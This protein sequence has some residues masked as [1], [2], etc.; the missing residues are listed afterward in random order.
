MVFPRFLTLYRPNNTTSRDPY[1]PSSPDPP[2]GHDPRARGPGSRGAWLVAFL[3][4]GQ[5]GR[6][7]TTSRVPPM[8]RDP[9]PFLIDGVPPTGLQVL[10]SGVGKVVARSGRPPEALIKEGSL[11]DAPQRW[12]VFRNGEKL[13]PFWG[14]A[15]KDSMKPNRRI[16]E[17]GL[18]SCLGRNPEEGSQKSSCWEMLQTSLLTRGSQTQFWTP[19]RKNTNLAEVPFPLFTC[20]VAK[21][22]DNTPIKRGF[23]LCFQSPHTP[24]TTKENAP[25]IGKIATRGQEQGLCRKDIENTRTR[26]NFDAS[27]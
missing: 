25:R 22:Q 1:P 8:S 27:T 14:R 7:N 21:T 20:Y 17:T 9:L 2:S 18:A 24:L 3:S 23:S 6:G 26:G 13:L 12:Q 19:Y 11:R 5:F 10:R 4:R 15:L 16:L